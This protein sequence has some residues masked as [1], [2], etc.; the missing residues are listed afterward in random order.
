MQSDSI[1]LLPATATARNR[2]LWTF[3]RDVVRHDPLISSGV[4]VEIKGALANCHLDSRDI[5]LGPSVSCANIGPN[6]RIAEVLCLHECEILSAAAPVTPS[7]AAAFL[8][9][10]LNTSPK[11]EIA[12]PRNATIV[13]F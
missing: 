10:N 12:S 3:Q 1:V 9:G 4:R 11:L 13:I 6:G 7:V 5:D 8:T 2:S